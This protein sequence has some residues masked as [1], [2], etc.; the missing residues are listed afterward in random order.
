[1]ATIGVYDWDLLRWRSPIIFN[2]DLMKISY[3][4]KVYLKNYV[5]MPTREVD[6]DQFKYF[7]IRKDY[8]DLGSFDDWALN[9]KINIGGLAI[10]NGVHVP[11]PKEIESCPADTKIYNNVGYI[12]E[13]EPELKK[14]Y[15][16][17]LRG[18]HLRLISGGVLMPNWERQIEL[19]KKTRNIFLHDENLVFTED[20]KAALQKIKFATFGESASIGMKFPVEIYNEDDFKF[21][22]NFRKI[23]DINMMNVHCLVSDYSL[24]VTAIKYPQ[25][26]NFILSDNFFLQLDWEQKFYKLLV[27]THYLAEYRSEV[28]ILYS[29]AA[30][31]KDEWKTFIYFYNR[32]LNYVSKKTYVLQLTGYKYCK[33]IDS[34]LTRQEKISLFQFLRQYDLIFNLMFDMEYVKYNNKKLE[35]HMYTPFEIE[36]MGGYYSDKNGNLSKNR[37]EQFNYASITEPK[38]IYF[39][40]RYCGSASGEQTLT[41]DLW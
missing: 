15:T 31:I 10:S 33:K 30:E 21:W 39:E 37:A 28:E 17:M 23:K 41:V 4:N 1:M 9:S 5:K 25:T 38:R 6:L 34:V 40:Q 27:Q 19:E 14:I 22:S 8:D 3:Y 16:R 36:K 20:V 26:I 13:R 32:Y 11:L 18:Q 7:Y 2:L 12:Y 24:G 29:K 35:T